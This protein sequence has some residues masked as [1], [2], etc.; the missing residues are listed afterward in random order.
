MARAL[1]GQ[2]QLLERMRKFQERHEFLICAVNQVPPF[3]AAETWPRQID[4]T[5]MDTY[6]S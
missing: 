3:D 1:I 2:G 6:I 5:T 4:G